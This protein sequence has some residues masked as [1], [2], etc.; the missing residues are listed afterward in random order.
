[1]NK[2]KIEEM[3]YRFSD[4]KMPIV[5]ILEIISELQNKV[6]EISIPNE[7]KII[8]DVMK[9]IHRLGKLKSFEAE[10][11]LDPFK[12]ELK[13]YNEEEIQKLKEIFSSFSEEL[14]T[15]TTDDISSLKQEVKDLVKGHVSKLYGDW[16]N[17]SKKINDRLQEI[18]D[19][20]DADEE[21]ICQMVLERMPEKEDEE[22]TPEELRDKLETLTGDNRLD[23]S[24]IKGLEEIVTK[25]DLSKL[26]PGMPT[27]N[28]V[29]I[30]EI[31]AGSNIT[32]DNTN[33]EFPIVASTGG[34]GG[35]FTLLTATGTIDGTN[36]D[37]VFTEKPTYIVQHGLWYREN[38]GWTWTAGT[39]TATMSV[40]TLVDGDIFAFK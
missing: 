36:A 25:K 12:E 26:S 11:D 32:V 18:K 38:A 8:D 1:M 21:K 22:E 23:K 35:G 3:A 16:G 19:G 20:K 6:D 29:T 30:R 33:P 27:N 2:K 24:A 37:Y 39:L 7:Q 13:G 14:T 40:P 5:T 10:I 28:G 34:G 15:K 9:S 17:L 4:K 31:R